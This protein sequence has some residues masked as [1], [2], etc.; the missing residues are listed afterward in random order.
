M[1]EPFIFALHDAAPPGIVV[2]VVVCVPDTHCHSIV[3]PTL[4]EIV[5]GEKLKFCTVTVCLVALAK[6]K[7]DNPAKRRIVLVIDF[8]MGD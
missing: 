7:M 1:F 8:F 5:A 3:S 6:E 2:E 4:A